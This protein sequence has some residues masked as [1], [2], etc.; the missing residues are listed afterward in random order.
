MDL[1]AS[2]YEASHLNRRQL[3]HFTVE[4]G[5]GGLSSDASPRGISVYFELNVMTGKYGRELVFGL[6]EICDGFQSL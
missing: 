3:R 1:W 2:F 4:K 6:A 5:I